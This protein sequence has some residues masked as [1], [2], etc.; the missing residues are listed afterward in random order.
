[1]DL[2]IQDLEREVLGKLD[3]RLPFYFKYMGDILTA[4][5]KTAIDTIIDKFNAY[6]PRLQFS[7][8]RRG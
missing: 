3:F 7:G 8:N 6:H 2:V 5:P 4:V 1:M